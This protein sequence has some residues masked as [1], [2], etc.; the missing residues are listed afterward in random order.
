VGASLVG[1]VLGISAGEL[2]LSAALVAGLALTLWLLF[3][4]LV[5]SSFDPGAAQAVGLPSSLLYLVLLGMVAATAIVGMRVVGVILTVAVLVIPAATALRWTRRV[6]PAMALSAVV[7]AASGMLG[8]YVAYYTSIAP[9]AV[10][11][12]ALAAAF[13]ASVLIAPL[14][15]RARLAH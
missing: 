2:A 11:V 1:N 14:A 12:L 7:A 6:R 9:A 15:A 5:L 10:M 3:W 13:T 8:L 4:P